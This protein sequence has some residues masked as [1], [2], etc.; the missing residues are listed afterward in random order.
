MTNARPKTL[1]NVK[2]RYNG[3]L[4]VDAILTDFF[5]KLQLARETKPSIPLTKSHLDGIIKK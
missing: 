3:T 1:I 4:G 2:H 5:L